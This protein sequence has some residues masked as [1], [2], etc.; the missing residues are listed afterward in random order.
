MLRQNKSSN[1]RICTICTI[2]HLC[3]CL[4]IKLSIWKWIHIFNP[5]WLLQ[6]L[7]FAAAWF[8]PIKTSKHLQ[9]RVSWVSLLVFKI[10]SRSK[11]ISIW[12]NIFSVLV[13]DHQFSLFTALTRKFWT[14][15]GKYSIFVGF[16]LGGLGLFFVLFFSWNWIH[17][18]LQTPIQSNN[19]FTVIAYIR[20]PI[21]LP[22][23]RCEFSLLSSL[24]FAFPS[25]F[26][27]RSGSIFCPC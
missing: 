4:Q 27:V 1:W 11:L 7:T 24:G 8:S 14:R 22:S 17:H 25:C 12:S 26:A 23:L 15:A 21:K 16:V 5:R 6:I 9:R 2:T 20:L 18:I 19:G 13:I 10:R 3:E